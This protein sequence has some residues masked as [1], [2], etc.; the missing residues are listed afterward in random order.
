M[1]SVALVLTDNSDFSVLSRSGCDAEI[2]EADVYFILNWS[3]NLSVITSKTDSASSFKVYSTFVFLWCSNIP[4]MTWPTIFGSYFWHISLYACL[5]SE[6]LY[7]KNIVNNKSYIINFQ[8]IHIIVE[9]LYAEAS[10]VTT[11]ICWGFISYN[12][13]IPISCNELI[14]N[15]SIK[16]E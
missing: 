7:L 14:F 5:F 4:S 16:Y 1:I 12:Y 15:T 6:Q 2:W 10:S 3:F 9:L 13:A 8:E 11:I